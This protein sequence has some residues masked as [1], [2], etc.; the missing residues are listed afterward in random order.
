MRVEIPNQIT[1]TIGGLISRGVKA[2]EVTD[3]GR[4]VFTL[5][6][7]STVDLGS[8]IGP[9]GPKGETG[10]A[11]PQG[12]TGPAGAQ[13]EQGPKGDTGAEGPK[14]ATGDTG[15]K[16]E[17]GEKGEK[18]D[19][20]D[21]G[22][23]GPKGETG[24]Q[25]QTGPQGPAGP[26]GPKGDMGTGF[27]VKGYYGSVSALQA[28]VENPE[29][30][31]AYG[32]GAAAPYD[33][34]IY[35]GVTNAWVNN[36]PL[37][38]AKGDKGDPGEQGPKGEP[39]DTGPAGASGADGVT[40][41]I[42]ENG[43][44]Y[45]GN[46]DTGKPSRGAKGDKGDPGDTGPQGPKGDTGPQGQTGPQGEPGEKGE[47]G[48][49]G[50]AG[51]Q[52]PNAVTTETST[53]LTGILKGNGANVETAVP[54]TDYVAENELPNVTADDNGKYLR[55]IDGVW[56]AGELDFFICT[57]TASGSS[58]TCDKTSTQILAA[59]NAGKIPIAVYNNAV[60]FLAG[61]S[62]MFAKFTRISSSTSEVLT[63][64]MAGTA[65]FQTVTLQTVPSKSSIDAPNQV[66]LGDNAEYYL[67]NV[68]T[69]TFAF[70]AGT[71]IECWLRI[72]TAASGTITVTFPATVKYIGEAP[73][74]GAGETWEL[75]IKD[76]VVIAVKEAS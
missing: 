76:G 69:V 70:P 66:N 16:G 74:F 13:G 5:T 47:T 8:V 14:G 75:S 65:S 62:Q 33:I 20:G 51:S 17:P 72:T 41:T 34:Y 23:T 9:E 57:V 39:G 54:G 21:T 29:V 56:D 43:N 61:G 26:T 68:E 73:A 1:V 4:L 32:V 6:D 46:T 53:P 63:V 64:T 28:S 59:A 67:T 52:G 24:P 27:T 10:P 55:V 60:Y 25:G 45:L 19:K 50:P 58:Y 2:V 71:K 44:W 35:D 31:D 40:P 18:G 3:A 11:G 15:P 30:G 42:G 48:P 37:Q 12:Q 22:A 7:G 49:Q 36:G 38:G